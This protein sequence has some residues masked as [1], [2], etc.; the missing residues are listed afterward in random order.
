[1]KRTTTIFF[2]SL[3]LAT[4]VAVQ[5]QF[6]YTVTDGTVTITG[7]T[8]SGGS[9]T[10]P[11]TITGLPV[12]AIWDNAFEGNT[13]LTSVTIPNSVTS[14]G[15][16]AFE[17]CGSLTNVTIGHSVTR[18]GYNA[19][20]SCTSLTSVTIPNSVMDISFLAFAYCTSLTNVT[21]GNSVA[22]IGG[23]AFFY[24]TSLTSVTIPDSVIVLG[25]DPWG[26]IP[27]GVFTGCTNLLGYIFR[28]TLPM[29]LYSVHQT[30]MPPLIICRGPLVGAQPLAALQR[31]YGHF[32]IQC[33]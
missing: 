23:N 22:A 5:A 4:P 33:S 10:I 12:T 17:G 26:D 20:D 13:D 3:L 9:V 11:D 25:Y 19:F 1:M 31:R 21:I 30:P 29:V 16:G 6:N 14:I 28:V 18:I 8:G 2:C 15:W 32:P 24:C 27:F 7:Y